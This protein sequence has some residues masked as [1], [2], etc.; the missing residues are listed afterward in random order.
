MKALIT[1][2]YTLFIT[3]SNTLKTA[4]NS[5]LY[6]SNAPQ[7]TTYP[8]GI[9]F[10]ITSNYDFMFKPS[11]SGNQWEEAIIQFNFY[12]NSSSA[13]EITD[14]IGYAQSLFDFCSPTV[15]GYTVSTFEREWTAIEYFP[16][17]SAWQGSIQYRVLL[18]K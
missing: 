10:L 6:F 13:S 14:I 5:R 9:Y 16:E 8:F 17:Q 11:T 12:S 7:D 18:N 3:G 1:A 4:L 2:I 15:T